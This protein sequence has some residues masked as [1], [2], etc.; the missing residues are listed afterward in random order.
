MSKPIQYTRKTVPTVCRPFYIAI[1]ATTL[2]LPSTASLAQEAESRYG[3]ALE[4]VV[5]TAQKREENLMDVPITVNAFTQQDMIN[6]GALDIQDIDDYMP[7][8]ELGQDSATQVEIKIRGIESPNISTGGDP[9]IAVFYDGAYMPRAATSIPFSDVA[10]TEVLKG[11]QGTL[12]G[13][14]ATAGVINIVPNIPVPEFEGFVRSRIGNEGLFRA[15]GMVNVP[16]TDQLIARGN[17]FYHTRD[18]F[19]ENVGEGD[20]LR[21]EGFTAARVAFQYELTPDTSLRLVGDYE[22]RDENPRYSIGV[23]KYGYSTDPYNDKA[24]N[25]VSGREETREM[26]GTSLQLDHSFNEQLSL[27]GIVSYRDWDTTNLQDEDGTEDPR[28]YLDSNNIEDSDIFYTEFR[29]HFTDANWDVVFGAN[30]S[31]EDVYQ[32]TDLGILAD[33]YMQGLTTLLLP[34]IGIPADQDDHIWYNVPLSADWTEEDYLDITELVSDI[35]GVPTA[36]LPPRYEGVLYTETM[37]N[38]GDFTNWGIFADATYQLTD[39]LSVTAGLRYS[40]DEK[41]YSW[42]TTPTGIE[43]WPVQPQRFAYIPSQSGAPMDTWLGKFEDDEDWSKT[44][45]R[46]VLNWAF[47]DNA[48]TFLSYATGYKSGGFDGQVFSGWADGAYDPE[49]MTS[50]EWGL[51]GDFFDSTLRAEL[52]VFYQQLE[53]QQDSTDTRDCASAT[54]CSNDPVAQPTIITRDVDTEGFELVL[55]W[56]PIESLKLSGLTTM[57]DEEIEPESYF[58]GRGEAKGGRKMSQ[59]TDLDYTLQLD[60][61]PEIPRGYLLV[62]VDYV[63]NEAADDSDATI[64][65]TGRWYFQDRELLNARIAWSNDDDTFE[66]GIW[67]KNLQDNQIA[68]NPGGFVADFFGAYKTNIEDPRT[69]GVDFRYSF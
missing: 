5:V 40:Y 15:E 10:R 46:L 50:I 12:F 54:D 30:Y 13:R 9:S 37:I 26:Y 1:A 32:R 51:K 45:G 57:R 63:F 59:D 8:V 64:Y 25:D 49:E 58:D 44:T 69:Y 61:T 31:E 34:E 3:L 6:T 28:R 24:A 35:E 23:S 21:E 62:H 20:D 43:G 68:E 17:I 19:I 33:S 38:E 66:V 39:E 42:Q 36:V 4:E 11:P 55:Q 47:A 65:T 67:G 29:F 56:F 48:M 7:G 53:G 16:L 2:G 22:D 18:A 41:E 27:F 14:N 60:W 52:A